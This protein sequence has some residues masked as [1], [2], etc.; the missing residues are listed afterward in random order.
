MARGKGT[1][2]GK[3]SKGFNQKNSE[4]F[5]AINGRKEN[6]SV[7]ESGLQYEFVEQSEGTVSPNHSSTVTVHQRIKLI[8]GTI[9]D[10]TYKK[11]T[12]ES[13]EMSEAIEGYYEGL[14]MMKEGDRYRFYIPSDLAWGNRGAGSKIGPYAVIIIDCRLIS[15]E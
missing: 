12:P 8:D 9:V 3:G 7:T 15:V 2:K 6:I 11:N 5:L 14:T 1:K 13:F 4:E 10:D